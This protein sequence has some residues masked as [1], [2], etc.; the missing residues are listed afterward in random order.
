MHELSVTENIL[1]IAVRH[2]RQ[3][4]AT[5]VTDIH[6]II[7]QLSSIVDDSVQ[8]YWDMISEGSLCAGAKLHFERRPARLTCSEC[9]T[10]YTLQGELMA[11]PSCNS[12]QVRVVSGEEFLLQS[13]EIEQG[14][15]E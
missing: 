1:E 13:I 7:G 5:R 9:G 12:A 2:A 10:S 4:Q 15:E 6:I 3:A 14:L 11:C 8:F